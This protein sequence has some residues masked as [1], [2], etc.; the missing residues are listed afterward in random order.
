MSMRR[1]SSMSSTAL[2]G[3]MDLFENAAGLQELLYQKGF[4]ASYMLT[5]ERAWLEQ[6]DRSRQSFAGWLERAHFQVL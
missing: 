5:G 4:V 6:L 3:Q 1:L 2:R